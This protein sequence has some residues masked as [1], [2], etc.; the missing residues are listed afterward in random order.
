MPDTR[1]RTA[2]LILACAA[3]PLVAAGTANAAAAPAHSAPA[4]AGCT[5]TI[6]IRQF[7]FSPATIIAGQSSTAG[8][9]ARNCTGTVQTVSETWFGSFTG[10]APGIPPGCPAIDPLPEHATFPAHGQ[11]SNGVTYTVFPTCE[12]TAL[13]V[14]VE[15][16]SSTGTLLA[17]QSATL[18]ITAPPATT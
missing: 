3:L 8:L 9:V 2:A 1:S 5:G 15:I 16:T 17:E 10:A 14:T 7:A 4:P 11:L 12:A 18:A 13:T 6:Q